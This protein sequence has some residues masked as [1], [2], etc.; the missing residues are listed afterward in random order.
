MRTRRLALGGLLVVALMGLAPPAA[1]HPL[2]NATVSRAV[3]VV[4]GSTQIRITYVI[5]MAEIPAYAAALVID[6][7]GDGYATAAERDAWTAAACGAAAVALEIVVD[8]QAGTV[9][10]SGDPDLT[11]PPGVG[12]LETLR[13]VCRFT[14]AVP[15]GPAPHRIAVFDGA[16]DGRR[17]WRELTIA[18]A[19]GI[20]LV[21]SDVPS[22]SP[23]G[24]LT[25]Y[26]EDLLTAPLET[27]AGAATFR[28]APGTDGVDT[29]SETSGQLDASRDPL[30]DL[31]AGS[32]TPIAW[33]LAVLLAM[34][35]GAVHALSPGH[36][37]ALIAAYVIGSRSGVGQAVGLGFSVAASHTVGVLILGGIVLAASEL[38]VPERVVA[39]LAVGSGI[40]VV[41]VGGLVGARV[42]RRNRA[43]AHGDHGHIHP[44][45]PAHHHGH[46]SEG[47]GPQGHRDDLPGSPFHEVVA[48]GLVGGAIPSTS[49]LL[50]LLVAV[51][52]GRL[53]E[54]ML[55]I[56]AFGGGMAIALGSVA[57]LTGLAGS[58]LA[59]VTQR[60]GG[61]LARRLAAA[62]PLVSAAVVMAVGAVTAIGALGSL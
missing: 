58:R 59:R 16:D 43:E 62:A 9:Q 17:G 3:A 41:I 20:S 54:G 46:R 53:I 6:R 12:G 31:L 21:A 49:A 48:L 36:G 30:A 24:L 33:I 34:G 55:L 50:V 28:A 7:N 25:A 51:A 8:D 18:A 60:A 27:R 47:H 40:L 13:L 32:R 1:A 23:S 52:T 15:E 14:A 5:D 11:F 19:D 29:A 56:V 42:L 10:R 26:P 57:A 37:K 4:I 39:W 35:L 2:G 44:V 45:G 38:L 22:V 61:P